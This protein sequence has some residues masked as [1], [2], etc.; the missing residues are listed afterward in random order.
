MS[1]TD[2]DRLEDILD[3]SH[4]LAE[5]VERGRDEF[6]KDWVLRSAAERQLEIIGEA[7]GGLS[8]DLAERRPDWPIREAKAMRNLVSHEYFSVSHDRVWN[9]IT[10]SVPEFASLIPNEFERT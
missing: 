2:K 7:A 3:A 10:T 8:E 1:R 9:T 5:I 4:K 6:D